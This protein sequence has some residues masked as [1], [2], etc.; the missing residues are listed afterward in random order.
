L[1]NRYNLIVLPSAVALGINI[2]KYDGDEEVG[3]ILRFIFQRQGMMT[4]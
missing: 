4:D 2:D 3:S 1:N